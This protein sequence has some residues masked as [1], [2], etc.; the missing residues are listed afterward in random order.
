MEIILW[1]TW[2]TRRDQEEQTHPVRDSELITLEA[3]LI[4]SDVKG[5]SRKRMPTAS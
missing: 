2:E 4:L 1:N 5:I 3:A